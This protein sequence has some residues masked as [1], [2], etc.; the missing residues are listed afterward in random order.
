MAICKRIIDAH[1]GQIR[2]ESTLHQGTA[3]TIQLPI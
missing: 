2:A 3:I 1:E